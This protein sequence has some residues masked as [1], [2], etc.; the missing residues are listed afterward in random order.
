MTKP[1]DELSVSDSVKIGMIEVS[2]FSFAPTWE[3]GGIQDDEADRTIIE[4][5]EHV[6]A[7]ICDVVAEGLV[8]DHAVYRGGAGAVG[9][10]AVVVSRCDDSDDVF[11]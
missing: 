6:V 4:V 11:N 1:F 3:G 9:V 8:A 7:G 5:E 2:W 10:F